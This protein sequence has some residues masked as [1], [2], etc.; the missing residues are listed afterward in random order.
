LAIEVVKLLVKLLMKLY[1]TG[2]IYVMRSFQTPEEKLHNRGT[3]SR[4]TPQL[5][6]TKIKKRKQPAR[7]TS[8]KEKKNTQ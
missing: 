7:R 8:Q 4:R 5:G 2:P 1:Q 3:M 6:M